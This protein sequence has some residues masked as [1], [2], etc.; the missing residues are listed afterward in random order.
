MFSRSFIATHAGEKFIYIVLRLHTQ[1]NFGTGIF[2][3]NS[4]ALRCKHIYLTSH[5]EGG[6]SSAA[7]NGVV[8][9]NNLGFL[10]SLKPSE[11]VL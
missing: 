1:Q 10:H 7:A 8:V 5:F 4:F 11:V 2:I 6:F 3:H 9:A